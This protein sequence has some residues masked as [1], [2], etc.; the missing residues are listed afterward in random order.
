MIHK[1]NVLI[2]IRGGSLPRIL[3]RIAIPRVAR[4]IS[5]SLHR[6]YFPDYRPADS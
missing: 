1:I 6:E 4:D 5:V 2:T 3:I